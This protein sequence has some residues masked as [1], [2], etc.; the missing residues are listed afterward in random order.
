MSKNGCQCFTCRHSKE[1]RLLKAYCIGYKEACEWFLTWAKNNGIKRGSVRDKDL[2]GVYAQIQ[3]NYDMNNCYMADLPDIE[4]KD[5]KPKT[6]AKPITELLSENKHLKDLL[7]NEDKEV[8]CLRDMLAECARLC[9]GVLPIVSFNDLNVQDL[10]TRISIAL[11]N[12]KP[13]ANPIVANKI[14]TN[15]AKPNSQ[16]SESE[17]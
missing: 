9:E 12:N 4:K 1:P 16:H 8:E 11:G 2:S 13:Q 7:A 10:F 5:C 3:C 17:E 6:P 14:Q 15:V